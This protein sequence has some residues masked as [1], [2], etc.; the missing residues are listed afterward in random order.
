NTNFGVARLDHNL[1]DKWQLTSTFRYAQGTDESSDQ[2]DIAGLLPGDKKGVPVALANEPNQQRLVTVGLSGAIS[3]S[4]MSNFRFSWYRNYLAARRVTPFPQV[5]GADVALLVAG[6]IPGQPGQPDVRLLDQ[7]VDSDG[8]RSRSS[9]GQ[10]K[11]LQFL[12]SLTWVKGAHIF[13]FGGS[14]Y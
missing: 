4:L 1:N 6:G 3:S 12:A 14:L 13:S 10:S 7:P 8:Q 11:G 9:D 2:L 5:S